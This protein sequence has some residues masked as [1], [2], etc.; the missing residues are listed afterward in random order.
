MIIIYEYCE[1]RVSW[2][3]LVGT[4]DN[5]I[6]GFVFI[7]VDVVVIV[8]V[9]VRNLETKQVSISFGL[10]RLTGS[11]GTELGTI[12]FCIS[13]RTVWIQPGGHR[14][15]LPMTKYNY[16]TRDTPEV[17]YNDGPVRWVRKMLI[18]KTNSCRGIWYNIIVNKYSPET[19]CTRATNR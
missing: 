9:V 13:A 14:H 19:N 4:T 3:G 6:F 8:V 10:N 2:S 17:I 5:N 18:P 7:V 15:C 11:D 12:L 1:A 16:Y